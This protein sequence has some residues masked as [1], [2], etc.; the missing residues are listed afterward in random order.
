MIRFTYDA[1]LNRTSYTDPAGRTT[2][3]SYDLFGRLA[4]VTQPSGT[5]IW[6]SIS[7]CS[8]IAFFRDKHRQCGVQLPI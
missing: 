6:I 5:Q 4:T 1:N 7:S 3:Y 8:W 2:T